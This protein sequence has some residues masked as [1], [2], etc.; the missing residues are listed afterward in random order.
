[1]LDGESRMPSERLLARH[2]D[3]SRG[4]VVRAYEVLRAR[5]TAVTRRGSATWLSQ[6]GG[7]SGTPLLSPVLSRLVDHSQAAIDLSIGAL[8]LNGEL[9]NISVDLDQASRLLPAHGYAPLGA[10]ALRR[11]LAT[12]LTHHRG[13]QTSAEQILV[14]SGG[15]GALSLIAYTFLRPGDRVLVE[16]PSYPGAIE[17]FSRA[18][19]L[20]EAIERDHA[21]PIP[22]SLEAAL[23]SRPARLIYLV[24]TCHNPTGGI[25]SEA[26]RRQLLGVASALRVPVIEDTVMA[27]LLGESSAAPP[28]L[29][30]IDADNVLSVGSLSKSFW[31]GL[32]IG[33]IRASSETIS[34]LGRF[35]TAVDL[36]TPALSQLAALRV[37]DDFEASV[38]PARARAA[39]RLQLLIAELGQRLPDWS[40]PT[41]KGGLSLWVTLP[42]ASAEDLVQVALRHGVAI[43]SG[44]SAC[45]DGRF[46]GHLR[47]CAGPPPSLIRE[48][49]RRLAEAWEEI[50]ARPGA[51][52]F[53]PSLAL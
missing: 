46:S 47:L 31:G 15:S 43:S 25:M 33:W 30:A 48:G 34:R 22:A 53:Q 12:H 20:V 40:F 7:A 35:R 38:A 8:Q 51:H 36:G 26:R 5:G 28:D 11:G 27:D 24:P 16:A 37:L 44:V 39:E 21:G 18:G 41:P 29:A 2:L 10:G 52:L 32:R 19:A 13:V 50:S 45:P 9:A 4:T 14:T 1:M 23:A 42:H 17:M 3:V 6:S 49:V